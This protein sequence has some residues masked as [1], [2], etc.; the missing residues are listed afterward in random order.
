MLLDRQSGLS[1]RVTDTGNLGEY[2]EQA[3]V[4]DLHVICWRIPGRK[5]KD[6]GG[7]EAA[8]TGNHD[9]RANTEYTYSHAL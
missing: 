8:E 7:L 3:V 5:R 9:K 1:H 2:V 4:M 6:G